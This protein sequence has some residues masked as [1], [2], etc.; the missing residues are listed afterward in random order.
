M[1]PV[2]DKQNAAPV[3]PETASTQVNESSIAYNN[4]N[5]G[6]HLF[7]EPGEV[8]E[9]RALA[10]GP[11]VCS[12]HTNLDEMQ[13]RAKQLNDAG[14]NCYHTI[15]PIT[16]ALE[17]GS[18]GDAQITAIRWIPGDVDPVRRDADG[19]TLVGIASTE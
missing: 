16:S 9:L 2:T 5:A 10:S 4:S 6:V 3:A 18:A 14:Y 13:L 8:V 17:S 19:K 7:H 15:N 1:N 11:P 12:L